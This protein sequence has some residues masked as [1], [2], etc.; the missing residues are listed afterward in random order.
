LNIYQ[1]YSNNLINNK[2]KQKNL[3]NNCDYNNILINDSNF[4]NLKNANNMR[5]SSNNNLHNQLFKNLCREGSRYKIDKPSNFHNLNPNETLNHSRKSNKLENLNF[6]NTE[7]N[8]TLINNDKNFNQNTISNYNIPNP[9]ITS[10][11]KNNK[12]DIS[13]MDDLLNYESF[14]N[15]DKIKTIQKG[16]LDLTPI[17]MKKEDKKNRVDQIEYSAAERAAVLIRR[18]EYSYNLKNSKIEVPENVSKEMYI[19]LLIE[20][21]LILIQRWWKKMLKR[22]CYYHINAQKIQSVFRGYI[23]RVAF[24]FAYRNSKYV[25]PFMSKIIQIMR[26]LLMSTPMELL[27]HIYRDHK[28]F[29]L[30]LKHICLIQKFY[31]RFNIRKILKNS[32][33]KK[34]IPLKHYRSLNFYFQKFK[35]FALIMNKIIL[36]QKF[37]RG[38]NAR[39]PRMFK[40][41]EE[42]DK[43]EFE[44]MKE[45][46]VNEFKDSLL[47]NSNKFFNN[48]TINRVGVQSL[49]GYRSKLK[50]KYRSSILRM[51][52]EEIYI[53]Y[54]P[55]LMIY[56]SCQRLH[57]CRKLGYK[58]YK[59]QKLYVLIFVKLASN[60]FLKKK[61][62]NEMRIRNNAIEY[63]LYVRGKILKK[64]Y[65]EKYKK[66]IAIYKRTALVSINLIKNV[67]RIFVW[68]K[69]LQKINHKILQNNSLKSIKNYMLRIQ[70]NILRSK[71]NLYKFKSTKKGQLLINLQDTLKKVINKQKKEIINRFKSLYLESPKKYNIFER[72]A[73][74]TKILNKYFLKK[75]FNSIKFIELIKLNRFTDF[76]TNKV[77]VPKTLKFKKDI[78]EKIIKK[79]LENKNNLD[80][81]KIGFEIL[82]KYQKKNYK[83]FF[84]KLNE[85]IKGN[86]YKKFIDENYQ[87]KSANIV[88]KE[89]YLLSKAFNMLEQILLKKEKKF[90]AN[91]KTISLNNKLSNTGV[92]I[93]IKLLSTKILE[94]YAYF[95][96]RL[97]GNKIFNHF[98]KIVTEKEKEENKIKNISQANQLLKKTIFSKGIKSHFYKIINF[99]KQNILKDEQLTLNLR[100]SILK[101]CIL[102]TTN[103]ICNIK[104]LYFIKYANKIAS[105]R[106]STNAKII[107]A[108]GI[109]I[110]NKIK[111]SKFNKFIKNCL[112]TLR[113]KKI[114][115]L[116][117]IIQMINK[118]FMTVTKNGKR[119]INFKGGDSD[120]NNIENKIRFKL[121]LL[122]YK[123]D[124][125]FFLQKYFNRLKLIKIN[126]MN[127]I[128]KIQNNFRIQIKKADMKDSRRNFIKILFEKLLFKYQKIKE[129]YF[130]K[131]ANEIIAKKHKKSATT[132]RDFM[133]NYTLASKKKRIL[134][135]LI[136]NQINYYNLILRE[137][138][139]IFKGGN[140][141][142]YYINNKNIVN[143]KFEIKNY[144]NRQN[145]ILEGDYY[146]PMNNNEGNN[147]KTLSNLNNCNSSNLINESFNSFKS[148]ET[149]NLDKRNDSKLTQ[150]LEISKIN[151]KNNFKNKNEIRE[152]NQIATNNINKRLKVEFGDNEEKNLSKI[153]NSN[154]KDYNG[155][156]DKEN[157]M[158]NDTKD[159]NQNNFFK[160]NNKTEEIK[161]S[162]IN[163]SNNLNNKKVNDDVN[164]KSNILVKNLNVKRNS[165]L[166]IFDNNNNTSSRKSFNFNN[167]NRNH[168]RLDEN[169][170]NNTK[171]LN[172]N[173]KRNSNLININNNK[174][175][176]RNFNENQENVKNLELNDFYI[177]TKNSNENSDE[178]D[179]QNPNDLD[180]RSSKCSDN[181]SR[182]SSNNKY[183][184]SNLR[185]F[186]KKKTFTN[187]NVSN[188]NL[189]EE[190]N[191]DKNTFIN[192]QL[193]SNK[194]N[195]NEG[196]FEDEKT[197]SIYKKSN[198]SNKNYSELKSDK[199]NDD[200]NIHNLP[201]NNTNS[202]TFENNYL[203]NN[204]TINQKRVQS[205]NSENN[206]KNN[207]SNNNVSVKNLNAVN[208]I[209]NYNDFSHN[210]I[211]Q[212]KK[213]QNQTH[214][215]V[216]SSNE[217]NKDPDYLQNGRIIKQSR[218]KIN[219]TKDLNY[220]EKI[221]DDEDR[222]LENNFDTQPH[223]KFV[224]KPIKN[225]NDVNIYSVRVEF[226]KSA[227]DAY[228]E[229]LNH[230]SNNFIINKNFNMN[231]QNVNNFYNKDCNISENLS[232]KL[233]NNKK[234]IPIK[235]EKSDQMPNN[236]DFFSTN[237]SNY[238]YLITNLKLTNSISDQKNFR[239]SSNPNLNEDENNQKEET[240]D[241][242]GNTYN[243][244][245]KK[246]RK[247][248][249]T[250]FILKKD[251]LNNVLKTYDM[252][253]GEILKKKFIQFRN[254]INFIKKNL[255]ENKNKAYEILYPLFCLYH[256][257][258]EI[259]DMVLFFRMLKR[260][261]YVSKIQKFWRRKS[262]LLKEKKLKN[263]FTKKIIS[264]EMYRNKIL[265][266][267]F[268]KWL[269]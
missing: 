103:K 53:R 242:V 158:N 16:F 45:I 105:I 171:P 38:I 194:K 128:K 3:N 111:V 133:R 28:Q 199:N 250:Q 235:E 22:L 97:T 161:E 233:I 19:N 126:D 135:N 175:L 119:K 5:S 129:K 58:E 33:L 91:L 64:Y 251:K 219:D 85:F 146:D 26:R 167:I 188:P 255:N 67:L 108:F 134:L 145:N 227:E 10:I 245:N 170:L 46:E 136:N 20:A 207:S 138:F 71:F 253:I 200:K 208:Y 224:K 72:I 221:I 180:R 148:N 169:G 217:N 114:I 236:D 210:K 131:F 6:Y 257:K 151:R 80:K 29:E 15:M 52:K 122:C 141:T 266:I 132:L 165:N 11:N 60:K 96:N 130:Y 137:K 55:L 100:K 21:K 254:N 48:T 94:K 178:N 51:I 63:I 252:K 37:F 124:K 44:K 203:N 54:S 87:I 40:E 109:K 248:S 8:N 226:D 116:K 75:A 173:I 232:N 125:K 256:K 79:F 70:N 76:L 50:N 117:E 59:I 86:E 247:R 14:K 36:M 166:I 192:K 41:K 89:K 9:L 155:N 234:I 69:L 120:L 186:H 42:N 152:N 1:K 243:N 147:I 57:K 183:T 139:L 220:K 193:N 204:R 229:F 27:K 269:K 35:N 25:Y 162:I 176:K 191:H 98:D 225:S 101:N 43:K 99:L 159:I 23:F 149:L 160:K 263:F 163:D 74:T 68:R 196:N 73:Q 56:L 218:T 223:N 177:K 47:N 77:L 239:K 39:N 261:C 113:K 127:K 262:L 215:N 164:N 209:D 206:T 18:M 140:H 244:I 34:Y 213:N 24:K 61:E 81:I 211:L 216:S 102:K 65:F 88:K 222:I 32:F 228:K 157:T 121:I 142:I 110:M 107:S 205:N 172:L 195:F 260:D 240:V 118:I 92:N 30:F 104:G 264:F 212:T 246:Q 49:S 184:T 156:L 259:S 187:K 182:T 174:L 7:Q 202:N 249:F 4:E 66:V 267:A 181:K 231:L 185:E 123:F 153:N 265:Y 2:E 12:S 62:A 230:I 268:D 179:S 95:F 82:S 150:N 90:F 13:K 168:P 237:S 106:Y 31:R 189:N 84:I 154:K 197:S 241:F 190:E 201:N 238:N 17:P 258:I 78:Y 198:I 83:N 93:M 115:E 143:K 112:V 144:K 214:N